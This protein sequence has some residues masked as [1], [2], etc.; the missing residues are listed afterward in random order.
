VKNY[1][2][3]LVVV[4]PVALAVPLAVNGQDW[5][6]RVDLDGTVTNAAGEGL[7]G[8]TVTA[9]YLE[10]GTGPNQEFAGGNG[11]FDLDDLKPGM[12]QITVNG[13]HLGYIISQREVEVLARGNED[14]A[15]VLPAMQE[16]VTGASADVAAGNTSS[17][18]EKYQMLLFS[19]PN[20]VNLHHPIALSYEAEGM[21]PEALDEY[22]AMLEWWADVTPPTDPGLPV[23]M[24]MQAMMMAGKAGLYQR[25]HGYVNGLGRP[26]PSDWVTA[27][28]DLSANTLMDREEFGHA[29]R[30]LGVAIRRSSRTALPYYYRGMA[31]VQTNRQ[32]ADGEEE[33]YEPA[34]DDFQRFIDLSPNDSAQKRQAIDLLMKIRP[35]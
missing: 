19:L 22:D 14:L 1:V 13:T 32:L 12:W 34:A 35:Q 6:G 26:L 24:G 10:T 31:R 5:K 2:L 17:A 30:V 21:Y 11:D 33:N 15:F 7:S 18:R 8:S 3:R 25:M 23:E 4:L 28:V 27:F 9:V 29:I 20:N 16:L